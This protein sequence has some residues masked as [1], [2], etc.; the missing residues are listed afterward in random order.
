MI[1]SPLDILENHEIRKT[2]VQKENFRT[3]VLAYF[4]RHGYQTRVEEGS[5]HCRNILAGDPDKAKFLITAH[6]D[7]PAGMIVPNFI[8]PCNLLLYLLWQIAVVVLFIILAVIPGVLAALLTSNDGIA[9]FVTYVSYWLLLFIMLFGPANRHNANDNTSGVVTALEIAK[10]LPESLRDQV[11]FVLFD[12]EELGLIGSASHRKAHKAATETQLVLNLDCVGEGDEILFFPTKKLKKMD[13]TVGCL[14]IATGSFGQKRIYVRTKG[15]SVYPSDQR[16][17][18][19]GVGIAAFKR[20]KAGLYLD[21]IHT[22][23]DT[24][25]DQ[26]NVNLLRA[27]IISV[28]SNAAQ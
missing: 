25:L 18:P 15:F 1:E 16:N 19:L 14:Q 10:S 21:K 12:M 24:T 8:T 28:V 17:F 5:F 4:H 11:C 9:V 7:T 3:D 2:K 20:S 26:T 23:K 6:Y 22:R 13:A 27:A